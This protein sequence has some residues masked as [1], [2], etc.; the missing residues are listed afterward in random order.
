M[1]NALLW[2][3]P[4][5]LLPDIGT[6]RQVETLKQLGAA[7]GLALALTDQANLDPL[8]VGDEQ[9]RVS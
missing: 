5:S 7:R 9:I 3:L 1:R 6:T 4:I 2:V 8:S